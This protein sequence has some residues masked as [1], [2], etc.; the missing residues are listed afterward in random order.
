M[1]QEA[2]E[3]ETYRNGLVHMTEEKNAIKLYFSLGTAF[4]RTGQ[5][6]S[7]ITTFEE[8]LKHDPEHSASL[9]YL[10]YTLADLNMRL[11]YAR[12]LIARA[13]ELEPNN[14]AFLD[15]YGWVYFRLGQVDSALF[16]LSQA[17]QLDSDPVIYDH[18]GDAYAEK[19]DLRKAREWWQKAL[20]RQPDN[21]ELREKLLRE[22]EPSE[23]QPAQR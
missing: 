10:G 2:D 13:V 14:A 4:E 3:I 17:A 11:P 16:Y 8:I 22:E 12:D 18:L 6:D 9:N 23:G 15:S 21:E 1:G 7:A 5:V 19:G 20:D